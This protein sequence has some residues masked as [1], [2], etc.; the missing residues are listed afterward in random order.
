ML[1]ST[2][3]PGDRA[4]EK[5]APK[6][7]PLG[8]EVSSPLDSAF[9]ELS[10]QYTSMADD[11]SKAEQEREAA[12]LVAV[13]EGQLNDEDTKQCLTSANEALSIFRAIG[14]SEGVADTLR[15]IIDALRMDAEIVNETPDEALRVA[16]EELSKYKA[17]GDKRGQ[18]CMLLS[19]AEVHLQ[20]SR[21]YGTKNLTRAMD[22]AEGALMLFQEVKDR[23][24]EGVAQLE[25]VNLHY[26]K[27]RSK[28]T[29][30]AAEAALAIFRGLGD[31]KNEAKSL[32]G[33]ALSYAIPDD[34]GTAVKKAKE[35]LTIY[36]ELGNLKKEA[37]E[38]SIIADWYLSWDQPT[39]ALRC[40]QTALRVHRERQVASKRPEA[41][42]L[43]LVVEA[44]V[45][46]LQHKQALKAA[47]DGLAKFEESGNKR[48][49]AYGHEVMTR[50]HLA[51][52]SYAE[53]LRSADEAH[54]IL[55]QLGDK[56]ME[57]DL[58]HLI[59]EVN[60]KQ[61]DYQAAVDAM[62]DAIAIA[63]SLD[64]IE[65]E[66]AALEV[67]SSMIANVYGE[68]KKAFRLANEARLLFQ[69]VENN[70]GEAYGLLGIA[71]AQHYND[72]RE[73]ALEAAKNA[74]ELFEE[75]EFARGQDNALSLMA[76]LYVA[77][78]EPGRAIMVA[79]AREKLWHDLGNKAWE[80]IAMHQ[81]AHVH[82]QSEEPEMAVSLA[83]D[84]Q[85]L[86]REN[87][88]KR[89]EL[90]SML[91]LTDAHVA[92]LTKIDP[93][94]FSSQKP[95]DEF[96]EARE[97]A[98]DSATEA[99]ALAVK[100]HDRLFRGQALHA[101]GQLLYWSHR[102]PE[103]E[104]L[105]EHAIKLFQQCKDDEWE[106]AAVVQHAYI[107]NA[108]GE[109]EQ[110][111]EM[112]RQA[113][114]IAQRGNHPVAE[115]N[116][117]KAIEAIENVGKKP[118]VEVQQVQQVQAQGQAQIAQAPSAAQ[119]VAKVV[120]KG[121]D[122]AATLV[123]VSELVQNAVAT[124][125]DLENDSPLMESGMD[126]LASVAFMNDVSKAFA[127]QVSPALVFDYPTIRA[128]TD[129]LVETSNE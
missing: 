72:S 82:I 35:A 60:N 115:K 94:G 34:F 67:K 64:D 22:S 58:M 48:G 113:L 70:V 128:L 91:T 6:R 76:E 77:Y 93:D 69:K 71:V 86:M 74:L 31:R 3:N 88:N 39:K 20:D 19:L 118:Q 89:V 101:R 56:R 4:I 104:R 43:L 68:P 41:F 57:L 26:I 42:A 45:A 105:T 53:A 102:V 25:L 78:G 16:E 103:A 108:F 8:E 46:R 112:A 18:A 79:K 66:A 23:K 123:K 75:A 63:Q 96:V 98:L 2:G 12:M 122:P 14:A 61:K 30:A 51:M 120:K 100:V 117:E 52:D 55:Q 84:A 13:A 92:K 50:A 1:L 36:R 27:G 47:E 85:E 95:S 87:E 116:A 114:E 119:V 65:E 29:I 109:K 62:D 110:A 73:A 129:H 90:L 59:Y 11:G 28:A 111:L 40:A 15:I 81:V 10:P 7:K 9:E 99:L 125:E 24:M 127:L 80:A 83:Q 121:L 106:S 38:L 44:L 97:R 32:H 124:D 37:F 17:V 107:R 5:T 33:V 54:Q 49:I 21:F 126:S